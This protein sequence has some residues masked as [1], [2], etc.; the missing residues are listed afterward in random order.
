[1]RS[2]TLKKRQNLIIT[3]IEENEEIQFK[4]TENIFSNVIEENSPNLKNEIAI[5][6]QEEN[7]QDQKRHPP[8]HINNQTLNVQ[9]KGY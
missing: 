4:D 9:N 7:K 6:V 5:K 8:C 1:M 3:G 2:G